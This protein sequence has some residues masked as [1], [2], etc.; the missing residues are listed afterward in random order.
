MN[1]PKYRA[2]EVYIF[3]VVTITLLFSIAPALAQDNRKLKF[4]GRTVVAEVV[5][6][7][8]PFMVN[9]LGSSV[10]TG[11]IFA[12]RTDVMVRDTKGNLKSHADLPSFP[13][14]GNAETG[15]VDYA[16]N[17]TLKEYKRARPIVL[18]ANV[19]DILEIRFCNL[20]AGND[21]NYVGF[22]IMGLNLL[23]G[24]DENQASQDPPPLS[25]DSSYVGVNSSNS[26]AKKGEVKIYRYFAA[27]EGTFIIYSAA[28]PN[29]T[30]EVARGLFGC[31]AVEPPQA[32]YYRSQ[33]SRS[34]LFYSTYCSLPFSPPSLP[35]ALPLPPN[36]F[37]HKQPEELGDHDHWTLTTYKTRLRQ[38]EIKN[39]DV[40][41]SNDWEKLCLPKSTPRE[42]YYFSQEPNGTGPKEVFKRE[43]SA[44]A[45]TPEQNRALVAGNLVPFGYLYSGKTGHPI[46]DYS[47]VYPKPVVDESGHNRKEGSPILR[48]LFPVAK[49]LMPATKER[50]IVQAD[51]TP[52]WIKQ[53]QEFFALLGKGQS[54]AEKRYPIEITELDNGILPR[55][56]VPILDA[57]GIEEISGRT[58]VAP[59]RS[60]MSEVKD[61]E[62]DFQYIWLLTGVKVS[63]E[64]NASVVI[65]GE[66][67]N[68]QPELR[69]LKAEL[70]LF[71][72]DPTAI[73]TGPQAGRFRYSQDSPSFYEVP[74]LPDRRQPYREFVLGYHNPN[75]V[76]AFPMG[77]SNADLNRVLS[78][79]FDGF[80]INYGIAA[81][82]PEILANRLGFGP[83]GINGDEV[84]LKFE[85]FFLSSWAVGDPAM[86]VDRPANT[87]DQAV[88]YSDGL[89]KELNGGKPGNAKVVKGRA[90]KVIYPDDPS[91]VYHSYIRD[92][93]VMRIY[94]AGV[95]VPHVHHLHAHQWLRSPNSDN[96]QYLDS[97]L[98]IPGSAFSLD[99]VYNG[100]GNRNQTVGDSIFHCHF[101]PHF[102]KGMWALWRTH[103]VFE[104]GTLLNCETGAVKISEPDNFI[105]TDESGQRRSVGTDLTFAW[106]RALPDGEIQTGTPIPAIVPLPTIGMA[107]IPA[108]V[109]VAAIPAI[110]DPAG[111]N[112]DELEKWV[113]VQESTGRMVQVR[114]EYV[115]KRDSSGA[116]AID[117]KGDPIEDKDANGKLREFKD[118]N[119]MPAFRNPGYPFFV[120]GVAGHRPPHPPLAMA[121][122]EDQPGVPHLQDG[123]KIYLDGG[124]PRHQVIGGQVVREFHTRWDFTK[125]FIRYKGDDHIDQTE[126]NAVDG[127]LVAYSLPEDGTPIEV[128]AMKAHETRTHETVQPD[129]STGSFI[130]NGL[131]RINGAPFADPGVDDNGNSA[132]DLRDYKAAAIQKDVVFNKL[133][134]HYPQERFITL[135]QDVMPTFAEKRPPEP[136]FFRANGGETVNFWHTNL[137]PDYYELDDFQV[138]TPTDII[139]QHIHLVKFDVTSSDGAEN[140]FN[141]EDGVFS[142]DEVRG[143]IF[144]I[145]RPWAV[146]SYRKPPSGNV[147]DRKYD[148][149]A[150]NKAAEGVAGIK[151][152]CW[153]R[154]K[155]LKP[156]P[157]DGSYLQMKMTQGKENPKPDGPSPDQ[158]PYLEPPFGQNWDGAM[159]AIMRFSTDPLLNNKGQDRTVR[160][161]FTHDHFGPSTH[162][163]AGLY[164]GLLVEP[165]NSTWMDPVTGRPY[166][167][168]VTRSDGGPT[169]WEAIIEMPNRAES[170]R[171]FALELQ[172]LQLAYGNKSRAKAGT[173]WNPQDSSNASGNPWLFSFSLESNLSPGRIEPGSPLYEEFLTNGITLS[174][175]EGQYATIQQKTGTD[176]FWVVTDHLKYAYGLTGNDSAFYIVPTGDKTYKVF[177]PNVSTWMDW[178]NAI[179]APGSTQNKD[180]TIS[181][182]GNPELVNQGGGTYT[183]N[184]R[185]EPL[186]NSS[187]SVPPENQGRVSGK[188]KDAADFA[189]SFASI[190]REDAWNREYPPMSPVTYVT[191]RSH[192]PPL[193]NRPIDPTKVNGNWIDPVG[194]AIGGDRVNDGK[195]S[196][197][198]PY[199]P[200]LRGYQN[201]RVQI[202]LLAGAHTA[203]HSFT[204]YGVKWLF[205]PS[206]T[207]SGYRDAQG[208]GISEHFE[209]N[210]RLP[211]ATTG[212]AGPDSVGSYLFADYLYA[213]SSE[214]AGLALGMWGIMRSYNPPKANLKSA[215]SGEGPPIQSLHRLPDAAN[216]LPYP[217]PTPGV[218]PRQAETSPFTHPDTPDVEFVVTANPPTPKTIIYNDGRYRGA[219]PIQNAAG[220]VFSVD[221]VWVKKEGLVGSFSEPTPSAVPGGLTREKQCLLAGV[222]TNPEAGEPLIIR[223]K[224]G[225]WVKVT[226]YNKLPITLTTAKNPTS[227]TVGLHAQLLA[228]DVTSSDGANVGFNPVQTV[229]GVGSRSMNPETYWWY[230][231]EFRTEPKNE[232]VPIELGAVNLVAPDLLNQ[233]QNGLVGALIVEPKISYWA[234]DEYVGA[235]AKIYKDKQRNAENLLF[236]EYVLIQQ[237]DVAAFYDRPFSSNDFIPDPKNT[238][239]LKTL[240]A[241]LVKPREDDKVSKFLWKK[242]N[243]DTQKMLQDDLSAPTSK[244]QDALAIAYNKV[245]QEE[246]TYDQ[247]IFAGVE[248]SAET[249]ALMNEKRLLPND[250]LLILNRR[251]LRDAYKKSDKRGIDTDLVSQ[252]SPVAFAVNNKSED[253][254]Y[255]SL[256]QPTP[257]PIPPEILSN[258]FTKGKPPKP[259]GDPQT[260][261]F[262]AY[263]G[264]P[265]RFRILLPGGATT[266]I[267]FEIHGHSWQEEPYVNNSLE[268][269][270]NEKSQVLGAQIIVPNQS[271]NI[272]IDSAGGRDMT[273]GDYLFYDYQQTKPGLS[274]AWGIL[275]VKS[276]PS[277]P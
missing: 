142:P 129:G 54:E 89:W 265:I 42:R 153:A 147:A 221:E 148:L 28:P 56:L 91:N 124:L 194:F 92:H 102:A 191:P 58:Q 139:G 189:Y 229:S 73:I 1:T 254:G 2:R 187:I 169:G 33:V 276:P 248:L 175:I 267:M 115:Y 133:G 152:S 45:L 3:L 185:N 159:T 199:T 242:F 23:R 75:V 149:F 140:G 245:A 61:I 249:Q 87:P 63:K 50:M 30:D 244:D 259:D 209:L 226:L 235:G 193:F 76:Q 83:E 223:V 210:F 93:V 86:L 237:T 94:N 13:A 200:L 168:T 197:Y 164:G 246:A 110:T 239:S 222:K 46:I 167:D 262:E 274:G 227:S 26:F 269:G 41:I 88:A 208:L 69:F 233:H 32:E 250:K 182:P 90:T 59:E 19:G 74:A 212:H 97:E 162:Q 214:N 57:W 77:P 263:A 174:N 35:L 203:V 103:D 213:P 228:Y 72:S 24:P 155:P 134:W 9:R 11:Q 232:T 36:M 111:T 104:E 172:D 112:S 52:V 105:I 81:I 225:S 272:L 204:A 240:V 196:S 215:A 66:I 198:D 150:F 21:P 166:Y 119:G 106:V 49:L 151:W 256:A 251:L 27:S 53:G 114:N 51:G 205:E 273:P 101:Y 258:I 170:Y 243:P 130:L 20:L 123:H 98:I 44:A 231:G 4:S 261:I 144:A 252:P 270:N 120:P 137:V 96:S 64:E 257:N 173:I 14:T 16:G 143:R 154:S 40:V 15:M 271:L 177:T 190:K 218:S 108:H 48:M 132:R 127:A 141:Y 37:L 34:D 260:P 62:P 7:D 68:G 171:E 181:K 84:D 247:D 156:I 275:R 18:R 179:G 192:P 47:A 183:F 31:V 277:K 264:E 99:M 60:Y 230:A 122:Q 78:N 85:E 71:H 55:S 238:S 79:G 17:V 186:T 38:E 8:Q 131:P 80:A 220:L 217:T 116:V 158:S 157:W 165:A 236:H 5:A 219:G 241:T 67:V 12:L 211:P 266:P 138:R 201:D 178:K 268:L 216:P 39:V 100:S 109:R 180:G 121:W 207:D 29:N 118:S 160:T 128:G 202:R 163:Q 224:A 176:N 126:D 184:Y 25:S 125:D 95:G 255:R 135:W 136:F 234:E 146:G 22:H 253:L 65:Q 117:E 70:Q 206:Y 161:V 113:N 107:P 145:T 43:E 195:V 10:P 82:G 188:E 6:L